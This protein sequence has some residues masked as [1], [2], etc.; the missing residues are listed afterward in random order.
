MS[1]Y[2]QCI[3][4]RDDLKLSKGKLAVQVAHAAVSAY[5]FADRDIRE[6]WKEGGQKKVV[7]RVPKLQDLFELKET[8]RRHGL[9]TALITDAG[10][11]EV[12]PGTI[13]VLGIGPAEV[14][15]LDK[16]TGH[17]KLL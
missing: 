16:I 15:M 2:K 7:L 6:A 9:S 5:E 12:P 3:I 8:A 11:T 17:L 14:S 1:E 10:L 13:T 4:V